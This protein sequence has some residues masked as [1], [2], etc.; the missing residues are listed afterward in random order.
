M[1]VDGLREHGS[2]PSEADLAFLERIPFD[3]GAVLAE[4]DMRAFLAN[5]TGSAAV[6]RLFYEPTCSINGLLA[7]YTGTGS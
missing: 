2:P 6:R 5:L 1:T 3:A 4:H 7:G